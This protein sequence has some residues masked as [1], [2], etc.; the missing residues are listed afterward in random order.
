MKRVDFLHPEFHE[1][2]NSTVRL[3]DRSNDY[4]P[5]QQLGLYETGAKDFS[6]IAEVYK[7]F[8]TAYRN[9]VEDDIKYQHDKETQTLEGLW[10]AMVRAYGD[11]ITRDSL[12]TVI[13]FKVDKDV[14]THP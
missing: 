5:G 7:V 14:L 4:Y 10:S 8:V 1:G 13:Y 3:N 9:L 2:L 12:V 11:K 6:A